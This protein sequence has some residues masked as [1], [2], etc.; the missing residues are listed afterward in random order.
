VADTL[1]RIVGPVNI[2]SGTSTLFTGTTAHVYTIKHMVIVN[3]TAA[4]ITVK[5][6]IQTS[7]G[8]LDDE[9]LILPT[10]TIDA[11]G[12]AEFDGLQILTGTEVIRALAS[13]SGLTFT[14]TGLD[15]S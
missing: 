9:D 13:A 7:A 8:T 14:A 3:N 10:A 6:G 2:A 1:K 11:G 5:L 12:F 4:D 15:Q